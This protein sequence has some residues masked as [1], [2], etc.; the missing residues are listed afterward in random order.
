MDVS[1][2]ILSVDQM[3]LLNLP[4]EILLAIAEQCDGPRDI[5]SFACITRTTYSILQNLVYE[6]CARQRNCT[7]LH[8]AAKY[9]NHDT[10]KSLLGYGV[11]INSKLKSSTALL[12]AAAFGSE[13]VIDLLLAREDIDVNARNAHGETAL[14]HA[15]YA[16]RMCA[17][18]KLLQR[19]DLDIDVPDTFF[20]MTPFAL[21]VA[22]GHSDVAKI[23]LNSGR[24][25]INAR[26]N[27]GRTPLH[28]AVISKQKEST[29]LLLS[30]WQI[31]IHM[32]DETKC[33]PFWYAAGCGN[34]DAA[35]LLIMYGAN[36]NTPGSNFISPL[37]NAI[38]ER[39]RLMVSLLLDQSDINV[40]PYIGST[41]HA[42]P[43]LTAA[44]CAGDTEILRMLLCHGAE[45]D[46]YS[47]HGYRPLR[48]A[49]QRRDLSMVK[50]L[51]RREDIKINET[52]RSGDGFTALHQAAYD[53]YLP[54]LNIL[55]D[56][57]D[58]SIN[59]K[60]VEGRTPIW[61]AINNG[62]SS[63]VSRL[64]A[65]SGLELDGIIKGQPSLLHAVE[66]RAKRLQRRR[67]RLV[68]MIP[69]RKT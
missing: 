49:V 42:Q 45:V 1:F 17:V 61:W 47:Y 5:L 63:V 68:R 39:D 33:T 7:A 21:A 34:L 37:H 10:A 19:R 65:E 56:Q 55:L 38:W 27:Q 46:T 60:D 2:Y 67:M 15:A 52:G 57:T 43:L 50:L 14:W 41:E 58:I 32:Q 24:A 36:P 48:L 26:D 62:H 66:Q 25:D 30:R 28:H 35:Q 16:G 54:M 13:S 8:Y 64:L 23:L 51:L 12:V 18:A 44:V 6:S 59:A 3:G 53:G 11:N 4:C 69:I 31:G 9:D 29:L 20:G 40:S 22:H